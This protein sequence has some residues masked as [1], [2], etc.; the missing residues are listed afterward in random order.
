MND[1]E[2]SGDEYQAP[3]RTPSEAPTTAS[4]PANEDFNE[5]QLAG[6]ADLHTEP[7][8]K[9]SGHISMH[10]P[11]RDGGV[12]YCGLCDDYHKSGS[13][14]MTQ[15]TKNLVEYRRMLIKNEDEPYDK[16][17]RI[18]LFSL[19][20]LLTG[21]Q[22]AAIHAIDERLFKLGALNLI[23]D[24]PA[25]PVQEDRPPL[26]SNPAA[27]SSSGA[28]QIALY[29]NNSFTSN[30]AATSLPIWAIKA[31]QAEAPQSTGMQGKGMYDNPHRPS[32]TTAA[33][34]KTEIRIC[35]ICRVSPFHTP[36]DCPEV[37]KGVKRCDT[38]VHLA[39]LH[40]N[41]VLKS[42]KSDYSLVGTR[43]KPRNSASSSYHT[44][45]AETSVARGK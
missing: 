40:A 5:L 38:R 33:P 22:I 10:Y 39:I 25:R 16:R 29:M 20:K 1:S 7:K 9:S 23:R 21:S 12:E 41:L 4:S 37:G 43:W 30:R 11:I 36:F 13:C 28:A 17:V 24:Q 45:E 6:P 26:P 15:A 27:S 32:G 3:S 34:M 42:H 35:E 19:K 14:P 8:A 18:L 31:T 44:K 2:G